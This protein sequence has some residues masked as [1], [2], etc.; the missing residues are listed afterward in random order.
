LTHLHADVG[1][2]SAAFAAGAAVPAPVV[3]R[4]GLV[5]STV[6]GVNEA[7]DTGA[8]IGRRVPAV[9]EHGRL[10]LVTAHRME[11]Q[12][13]DRDLTSGGVTGVLC[14]DGFNDFHTAFLL[15]FLWIIK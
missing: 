5:D 6:I 10:R 9:D 7:V 15:I 12:P 3:P 4:E 8:V 2:V 14:Q 13:F 11:H 1:V